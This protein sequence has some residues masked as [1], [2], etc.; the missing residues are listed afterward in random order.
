M[1][2]RHFLLALLSACN[3]KGQ[4]SEEFLDIV[5]S[6][7]GDLHVGQSEFTDLGGGEVVLDAAFGIEVA[8][9]AN[10]HDECLLSPDFPDVVDPLVEVAEGVGVCVGEGVLVIS[11]TMTAALESLMYEGMREWKRYWPAVSHN[12][13]RRLLF[14]TLIVLETKSTPTVG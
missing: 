2:D 8:L 10:Y 4:L 9:V 6:L 11:K 1:L 3:H 7:G 5:A 13:M 14:S 12:C